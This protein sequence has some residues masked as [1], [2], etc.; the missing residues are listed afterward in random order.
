MSISTRRQFFYC[1]GLFLFALSVRLYTIS[2]ISPQTDERHW[3]YRSNEIIERLGTSPNKATTHIGHPGVPPALLMAGAQ[4][5]TQKYNIYYGLTEKDDGYI[6]R[7]DASRYAIA[8]FSSLT[9]PVLFLLTFQFFGLVPAVIAAGLLA[10]DPRHIGYSRM[11]HL[12]STLTAL[13]VMCTFCYALA[14]KS[15]KIRWKILA[16]CFWGLSIATKPTAIALVPAFLFFRW[17]WIWL[18]RNDSVKKG[19]T[20]FFSWSDIATLVAGHITF[21]LI[22][23]RLWIHRSDYKIRLKIKSSPADWVWRTG[24]YL[25]HHEYLV[26]GIEVLL[27][28]LVLFFVWKYR[29]S[30]KRI[31]FHLAA[32]F[33][34]IFLSV[35]TIYRFPQVIENLIR[36][37]F[38]VFGLSGEKHVSFSHTVVEH[39]GYLLYM[40]TETPELILIGFF[41]AVLAAIYKIVSKSGDTSDALLYLALLIPAIW[42]GMLSVSAKQT[43]RYALPVVPFICIASGFGFWLLIKNSKSPRMKKLAVTGLLGFQ[44]I[45]VYNWYP[46]QQIYINPLSGGIPAALERHQGLIPVGHR[47]LVEKLLELAPSDEKEIPVT[48]A[49]DAKTFEYAANRL[50][51]AGKKIR[52]R[53]GYYLP[54]EALFVVDHSS[55]TDQLSEV[56]WKEL[57]KD[58][59][60][61]FVYHFNGAELAHIYAVP[62]PLYDPPL[63][64]RLTEAHMQTG[65]KIKL[66]NDNKKVYTAIV[67]NPEQDREG[68]MLFY[69][70][71]R[72][73][74]GDYLMQVKYSVKDQPEKIS[75]DDVV[76]TLN[77]EPR[78]TQNITWKEFV[79]AGKE[80]GVISFLCKVPEYERLAI[81]IVW[82]KNLHLVVHGVSI[83]RSETTDAKKDIVGF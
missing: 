13:V 71:F 35:A 48:V 34:S 78:C 49:G 76:L 16:G 55:H 28:G 46:H 36:F 54:E 32:G 25:R 2:Q 5:V 3:V 4:W 33:F 45:T 40:V 42:L 1:L 7:F 22:Y 8:I 83:S 72:F 30:G 56:P 62:V 52:L 65:K 23:T 10:L 24:K 53:F 81:N 64:L 59:P 37:W 12:D 57:L 18:Q 67:V 43:W 77:F 58:V 14:I 19:D 69:P 17:V 41:I 21:A 61:A 39:H 75:E 29:R 70:I 80:A 6:Y 50:N 26:A 9:I 51:H 20:G 38:W 11:A 63:A 31:F 68:H 74:A 27:A 60:P 15:G 82:H 73:K 47:E 66:R 79:Q 44:L